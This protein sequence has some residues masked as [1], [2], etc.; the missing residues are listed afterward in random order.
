M[1]HKFFADKFSYDDISNLTKADD[2]MIW[3]DVFDTMDISGRCDEAL[4]ADA[5]MAWGICM[6][7]KT[8][9]TRVHRNFGTVMAAIAIKLGVSGLPD[10]FMKWSEDHILSKT[11]TT[12]T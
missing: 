7:G 10:S 12:I 5:L 2:V 3:P 4:C 9:N 8:F 6:T 11:P 1:C